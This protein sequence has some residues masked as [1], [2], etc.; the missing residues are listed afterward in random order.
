LAGLKAALD[1][2]KKAGCRTAH[3]DGSFV[4]MKEVPQDFDGCWDPVG[5]DPDALDPILLKFDKGRAA[6]K[7]KFKGELF[8]S[9]TWATTSGPT[10]LEFFQIDKDSG[11]PKGVIAIDLRRLS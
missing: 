9:S 8:P 2:L 7:A 5:V 1:S 3:I 6:Q 11:K 10:F 4:S